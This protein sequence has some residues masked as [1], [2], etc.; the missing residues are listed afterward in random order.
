MTQNEV[1]IIK[2]AVL[3]AT[4]AYVDARLNVLDFVKT[5]IGVTVGEPAQRQ[6]KYYHT[7]RCNATQST[8]QGVTYNNVLSVGNIEFPNGSVV[9][10]AAPNAQFSSQFILGKLDNTPCNIRGGSIDIGDGR[11]TVDKNGNVV[12]KNIDAQGGKI[13][14]FELTNNSLGDPLGTTYA[15]GMI[16]NDHIYAWSPSAYVRMYTNLLDLN[17]SQIHVSMGGSRLTITHSNIYCDDKGS[18]V[19]WHSELSDKNYKNNI[20]EI[21][22]DNIQKFFKKISPSTF[23][24]NDDVEDKDNLTHCGVIAQ[25]LKESLDQAN[26]ESDGLV[27]EHNDKMLVDYQEL[28]GLELAGIKDLYKIIDKQ[29]KEIDN[30]KQ[31]VR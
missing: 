11:F 15:V 20:N 17:N 26:I 24:F 16:S 3:D 27:K 12:C 1:D 30:L 14:A 19:V 10:V 9:F 4:E 8:P 21:K 5:Q 25:N 23:K 13:G 7:V 2:N 18:N 29:Q 28:H 31:G 6:G 22:S